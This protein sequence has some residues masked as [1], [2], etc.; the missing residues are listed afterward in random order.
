RQVRPIPGKLFI[1]GDPKQSIYRF[2]RADVALY[3]EVKR[4]VIASGG[5]L[6]DLNVSFRSVPEIQQAVNAAFA[7][8]MADESLTQAH[9]VPLAPIRSGLDTQPAIV[10]LP[11]SHPYGDYGRVVD[12]KID[13]SLPVD[14]AAFLSWLIHESGWT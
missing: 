12:W 1:V 4:Q 8:V 10:A 11:V 14:V 7:P 3:Q 6:V 5:A 2:R 9:Y 13:E